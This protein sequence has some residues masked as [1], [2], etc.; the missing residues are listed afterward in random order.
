MKGLDFQE[1]KWP[2]T[3]AALGPD[4]WK[5]E[6]RVDDARKCIAPVDCID[7]KGGGNERGDP[8]KR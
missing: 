1:F 6:Q 2:P 3:E 8:T 5:A 7:R 4:V